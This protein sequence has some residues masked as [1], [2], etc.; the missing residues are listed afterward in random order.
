M[1]LCIVAKNACIYYV[2]FSAYLIILCIVVSM[3]SSKNYDYL[4]V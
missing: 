3:C 4:S 2:L 1:Y